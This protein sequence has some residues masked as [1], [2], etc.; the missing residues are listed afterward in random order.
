LI[1]LFD[2][3]GDDFGLEFVELF[4]DH[5]Y[6]LEQTLQLEQTALLTPIILSFNETLD[7][8]HFLEVELA[9]VYLN[10]VDEQLV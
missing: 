8:L 9:L 7:K 1:E 3:D 6:F 2:F 4:A 10:S 5:D